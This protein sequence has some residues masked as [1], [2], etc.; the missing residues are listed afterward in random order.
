MQL[1]ALVQTTLVQ[2]EALKRVDER[3][4]ALETRPEGEP[5]DRPAG[6]LDNMRMPAGPAPA[7]ARSN[8]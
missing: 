1:Y 6:F 5:T 3:I 4:R 2:D 8:T 7:A